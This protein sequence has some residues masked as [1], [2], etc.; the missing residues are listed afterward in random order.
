M[1][2]L[3]LDE[4]HI[5]PTDA[6]LQQVR[7]LL[8][9]SLDLLGPLTPL[10][11]L[12]EEVVRAWRG[13][14]VQTA[15]YRNTLTLLD[16]LRALPDWEAALLA[17]MQEVPGP[18]PLLAATLWALA[19]PVATLALPEH[20]PDDPG[21]QTW[22]IAGLACFTAPDPA[23]QYQVMLEHLQ[24]V[25]DDEESPAILPVLGFLKGLHDG[26]L[27]QPAFEACV[28]LQ[29]TLHPDIAAHR[30]LRSLHRLLDY[31]GLSADIHV[32]SAYR[33]L[34][35]DVWPQARAENWHDWQW[36]TIPGGPELFVEALRALDGGEHTVIRL[37]EV[38][39]APLPTWR[40]L[41]LLLAGVDFPTQLLAYWLRPEI[42]SA[43]PMGE[44]IRWLLSANRPAA[45]AAYA[46][47]PWWDE[48][49]YRG[50]PAACEALTWLQQMEI[51][52]GAPVGEEQSWRHAWLERYLLPDYRRLSAN[53]L[54]A[55][56]ARG[57]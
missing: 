4:Q 53:L 8:H 7:V 37:Y 49:C 52:P 22:T 26:T 54:L 11:A 45:Q 48:W 17:L 20:L 10:P 16:R 35:A 12:F 6:P 29:Q 50:L 25:V 3:S 40:D 47:P 1:P 56:A 9:G 13:L 36:V 5:S 42:R 15:R 28:L 24:E 18:L 51:P 31:L 27:T 34:V 23:G 14:P 38:R 55:Q 46:K 33:Q 39:Y 41:A 21:D 43:G 32:Q 30:P 19:R 57:E 44:V 2:D